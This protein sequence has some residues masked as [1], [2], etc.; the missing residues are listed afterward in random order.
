MLLFGVFLIISL[1]LRDRESTV[2]FL[3]QYLEYIFLYYEVIHF[4]IIEN[5]NVLYIIARSDGRVQKVEKSALGTV[6]VCSFGAPKHSTKGC[7]RTYLSQRDLQSHIA[8][9]HTPKPDPKPAPPAPASSHSSHSSHAAP[10]MPLNQ[11]Q[12]GLQVCIGFVQLGVV[13]VHDRQ[14]R[15]FRPLGGNLKFYT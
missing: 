3:L 8:H 14:F 5:E 6:F 2:I 15:P 10:M 12:V 1:S 11:Q 4:V 7:R 9:R 13:Q